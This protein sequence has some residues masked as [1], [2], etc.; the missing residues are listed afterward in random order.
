MNQ[1]WFFTPLLLSSLF[2]TT[3]C[4]ECDCNA[5]GSSFCQT[6]CFGPAETGGEEEWDGL[7]PCTFEGVCII[8]M[9][10][11]DPYLDL[12]IQE[13][14]FKPYDWEG[15]CPNPARVWQTLG[16]Y[17][18]ALVEDVNFDDVL[19]PHAAYCP[20]M[21]H[22]GGYDGPLDPN[23]PQTNFSLCWPEKEAWIYVWEQ[24]KVS[25]PGNWGTSDCDSLAPYA[26]T[27]EWEY[28]LPCSDGV[29]CLGLDEECV[30]RC[31][32]GDD[33]TCNEIAQD[34]TELF[35]TLQDEELICEGY[36]YRSKW[37]EFV[38][39]G[40]V[41]NGDQ[42]A[43]PL[44]RPWHKL[45]VYSQIQCEG[46]RASGRIT[47][48]IGKELREV[49]QKDPKGL[50]NLGMKVVQFSREDILVFKQVDPAS[51]A[52]KIGFLPNDVIHNVSSS[53]ISSIDFL[54]GKQN[55]HLS[56]SSKENTSFFVVLV[57]N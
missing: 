25:R 6:L 2:L 10:P 4:F 28:Q 38:P 26:S 52:G 44:G 55:L 45:D 22:T 11:N 24:G 43:Q 7:L 18:P 49:A 8:D 5:V 51:I 33:T 15:T 9:D 30:C 21:D 36:P 37:D 47:C 19:L 39:T 56:V 17:F 42:G 20:N 40:C 1:R 12:A 41:W 50:L 48:K 54:E 31:P 53:S 23:Q 13:G 27:Y 34:A 35:P 57:P 29:Y 32:L 3:S 16:W 14:L 46:S